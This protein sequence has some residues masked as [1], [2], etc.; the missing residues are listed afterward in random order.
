MDFFLFIL[1][2]SSLGVYTIL[3]A[4]WVSNSKYALLGAYRGVSQVIS[5][6][7]SFAFLLIIFIFLGTSYNVSNFS[8]FT[9]KRIILSIPFLTVLGL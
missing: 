5:Y 3:G 9:N 4:G 1:V 6:E 8:H 7:V 2:I